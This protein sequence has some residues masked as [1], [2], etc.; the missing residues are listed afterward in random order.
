VRTVFGLVGCS[1]ERDIDMFAGD[2][3]VEVIFDLKEVLVINRNLKSLEIKLTTVCTK[4]MVAVWKSVVLGKLRVYNT[5]ILF[6]LEPDLIDNSL[7]QR[8]PKY[9]RF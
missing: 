8:G 3:L 6:I 2:P 5:I 7:Y 4:A 9:A 1:G